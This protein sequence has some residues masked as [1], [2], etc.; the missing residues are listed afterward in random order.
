MPKK[1]IEESVHG[2]IARLHQ[3][4]NVDGKSS[5]TIDEAMQWAS[6][7]QRALDARAK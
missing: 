1:T 2:F 6:E 5:M 4:Q 3:L 7:M